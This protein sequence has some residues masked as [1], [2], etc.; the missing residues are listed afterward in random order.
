MLIGQLNKCEFRTMM[1]ENIDD[2]RHHHR[3]FFE[4]ETDVD[5][6]VF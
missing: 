4:M 3:N 2:I 5:S 6:A 1:S